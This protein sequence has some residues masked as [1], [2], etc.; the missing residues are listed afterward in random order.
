MPRI[1]AP[2]D[3][4]K[5]APCWRKVTFGAWLVTSTRLC[6][7][8][9]CII[10]ADIAVMASGVSCSLCS[11]NWAVTTM[12][13]LSAWA[14]CAPA[15]WLAAGWSAAGWAAKAGVAMAIESSEAEAI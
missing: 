14:G 2:I 8:R 9:C 3:G 11:R 15:G 12:S 1:D 4:P 13:G 7:P 10:S 5:E 6:W